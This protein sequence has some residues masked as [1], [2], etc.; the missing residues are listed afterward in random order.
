MTK[1][2][3]SRSA[4][5]EFY[6]S[7]GWLA[8]NAGAISA[9]MPDYL[10]PYFENQFGTEYAPTVVDSKKRTVN[11]NPMQWALSMKV[12]LPKK[13][14]ASVPAVFFDYLNPNKTALTSTSFV[15]DLVANYGFQFGKTQDVDKIR[16]SISTE[17]LEPFEK[18]Y[19]E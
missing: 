19:A 8:K 9:A 7:L 18:G 1:K 10:L 3:K 14:Q 13:A 5:G 4:T 2:A 17:Y 11:G 15:W 6:Y 16:D 12:A